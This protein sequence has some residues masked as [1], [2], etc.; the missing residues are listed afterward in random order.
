MWFFCAMLSCTTA[1]G[2]PDTDVD[3]RVF[4][5][6]VHVFQL[7]SECSLFKEIK[8]NLGKQWVI[9][10]NRN[11][12]KPPCGLLPFEGS[13]FLLNQTFLCTFIY[14]YTPLSCRYHPLPFFLP[15]VT[16]VLT[17]YSWNSMLPEPFSVV[18]LCRGQFKSLFQD[19]KRAVPFFLFS[20]GSST[21]ISPSL[22]PYPILFV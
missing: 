17:W 6:S 10:L 9:I 18:L 2:C 7:T 4:S 22:Q 5:L 14:S 19:H 3:L 12:L 13:F 15:S 20:M 16:S 21:F 1:C 11:S 8:T